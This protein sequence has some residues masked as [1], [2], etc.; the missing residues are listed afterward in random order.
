[1]QL[2]PAV[3]ICVSRVKGIMTSTLWQF[4]RQGYLY[5]QL[6]FQHYLQNCS[7]MTT[8]IEIQLCPRFICKCVVI[9]Y[10]QLSVLTGTCV[11]TSYMQ[12]QFPPVPL[13]K[14]KIVAR[15]FLI[16]LGTFAAAQSF[17]RP[18]SLSTQPVFN[19]LM[20]LLFFLFHSYLTE[21][22]QAWMWRGLTFLLPFLA[23][24]YVSIVF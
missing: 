23:G 8:T 13:L 4:L 19:L 15:H 9:K 12:Q 2:G 5:E 17:C 16:R 21:G 14:G 7:G 24:G 6:S 11:W 10:H 22:F 1:M 18:L 3:C 20:V